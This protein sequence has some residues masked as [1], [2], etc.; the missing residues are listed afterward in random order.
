MYLQRLKEQT[1][2]CRDCR[3][4]NDRKKKETVF[5]KAKSCRYFVF[6][7]E[8][9]KENKRVFNFYPNPTMISD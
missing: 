3:I 6:K 8:R 9:K 4:V 2:S 5:S 1:N 7:D